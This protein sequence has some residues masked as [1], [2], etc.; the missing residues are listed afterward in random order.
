MKMELFHKKV[1]VGHWRTLVSASDML[2]FSDL[3]LINMVPRNSTQLQNINY[4]I[5]SRVRA[6]LR[7]MRVGVYFE[8]ILKMTWLFSHRNNYSI[9][10]RIML[11]ELGGTC[12]QRKL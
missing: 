6:S 5:S 4:Q 7:L 3:Q 1:N 8:R 12:Y 10:T 9:V 11:Y 2:M